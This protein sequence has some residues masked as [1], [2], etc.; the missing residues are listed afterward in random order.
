MFQVVAHY[1]ALEG[2]AEDVARL[3]GELARSS[4]EEEGNISY[5]IA[6]CL[7]DDHH[8]VI[9]EQYVDPEA[10]DVHRESEHFQSIGV[11]QIIPLLADRQVGSYVPA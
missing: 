11:A 2:K 9:A 5:V 10:F 3:L 1:H 6:R 7:E 8:F 4:R